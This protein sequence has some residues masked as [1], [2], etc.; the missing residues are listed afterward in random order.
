MSLQV[1]KNGIVESD[2]FLVHDARNSYTQI[3]TTT[4]YTPSTGTNSCINPYKVSTYGYEAGQQMRIKIT[5]KYSGFTTNT[6][7]NFNIFWQGA[8]WTSADTSAWQ[9]TNF[10]C[11]SLNNS[12]SLKDVVLTQ[13]TGTYTYDIVVTLNQTFLD[14]YVGSNVGIRS[15]YSNGSGNI[16]I[17][18]F[19]AIP[20]QYS[21]AYTGTPKIKMKVKDDWIVTHDYMEL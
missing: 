13:A 20:E 8:N 16:A 21:V 18:D 2:Y 5:V 7:D 17:I 6:N 19:K 1:Y 15:D 3:S 4:S 14:T 11:P 12:K 9:G 10:I